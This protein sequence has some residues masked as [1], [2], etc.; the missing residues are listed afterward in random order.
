MPGAGALEHGLIDALG[1]QAST[2]AWFAK[3]LG[4][5]APDIAFCE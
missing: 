4:L 3:E 1:N 2:R 5:A